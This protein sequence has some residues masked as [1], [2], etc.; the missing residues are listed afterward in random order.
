MEFPL[1]VWELILVHFDTKSIRNCLLW[2]KTFQE[3]V[4]KTPALMRK[5]PVIFHGNTWK[6]KI[7]FVEKHGKYVKSIKF[8]KCDFKGFNEI[9]IILRMTPKVEILSVCDHV[10]ATADEN[11]DAIENNEGKENIWC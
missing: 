5:L 10:F 1:E 3:L 6:E 2:S 4:I 11:I 7:P 8:I 9:K